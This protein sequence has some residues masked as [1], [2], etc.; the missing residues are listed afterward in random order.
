MVPECRIAKSARHLSPSFDP[1]HDGRG[2]GHSFDFVPG[3]T[4]ENAEVST[5]LGWRNW[6]K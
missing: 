5:T 4:S 1:T 3:P 6:E 2:V